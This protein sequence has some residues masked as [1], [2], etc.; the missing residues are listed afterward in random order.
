VQVQLE[1]P[2]SLHGEQLQLAV[3]GAISVEAGG[4]RATSLDGRLSA[5]KGGWL[6]PPG[7][8]RFTVERARAQFDG[9]LDPRLDVRATRELT[10]ALLIIEIDGRLSDP[11]THLFSDPASYD[12]AQLEGLVASGARSAETSVGQRM[13]GL[14]SELITGR[15]KAG[16]VDQLPL[17]VIKLEQTA[18]AASPTRLEV[19]KFLGERLYLG[20]VYQFGTLATPGHRLNAHQGELELHLPRNVSLGGYYGDAGTGSLD[21]SWTYR[22]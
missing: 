17:D 10:D 6:E 3:A 14:I 12:L 1:R 2:A 20:Y 15:V 18:G 22:R 13:A 7:G 21:L 16:L 4:G 8:R 19:G 5:G 11:R 9:G